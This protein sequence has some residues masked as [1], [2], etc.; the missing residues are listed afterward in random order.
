MCCSMYVAGHSK[1]RVHIHSGAMWLEGS[2]KGETFSAQ[3]GLGQRRANSSFDQRAA[4]NSSQS[5]WSH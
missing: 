2:E 4:Q 1:E 5:V 3:R